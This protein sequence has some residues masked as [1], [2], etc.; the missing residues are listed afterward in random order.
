MLIVRYEA[1]QNRTPLRFVR[2]YE[3]SNEVKRCLYRA[4]SSLAAA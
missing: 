4:R 3:P 1:A 2:D